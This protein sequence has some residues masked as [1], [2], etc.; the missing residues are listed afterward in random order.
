MNRPYEHTLT[1][2]DRIVFQKWL[3]R[4]SALCGFATLLMVGAV[5]AGHDLTVAMQ[6]E[7]APAVRSGTQDDL[8]CTGRSKRDTRFV[9]KRTGTDDDEAFRRC[10]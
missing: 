4:V 7:T 3:I 2:A 1:P 5:I 9:R 8:V 6:N 10:L